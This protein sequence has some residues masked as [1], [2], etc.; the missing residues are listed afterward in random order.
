MTMSRRVFN[1]NKGTY[2]L[3]SND[4]KLQIAEL[5]AE[6]KEE[7]D[8]EV[9]MNEGKTQYDNKRKKHVAMKP[10]EGYFAKAVR[11]FYPDIAKVRND[12]P[13]F[14]KAVK[15]ATRYYNTTLESEKLKSGNQWIKMWQKESGVSLRKPN[16]C[17]SIKKE[18][19]VE[20]LQD[21]LK[22]VWST[23]RYFIE[24]YG[25]DPPIISG[26]QMPLH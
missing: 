21:Y 23:R 12:D 3:Y 4:G 9:A 1:T 2:N 19:L 18:D 6:K 22:N 7:Y 5:V 25:I 14:C 26:D 11:E 16:N 8:A 13:N 24:K 10:T 20:R 17:Y 15:L